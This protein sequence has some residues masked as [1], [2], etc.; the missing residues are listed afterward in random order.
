MSATVER[1]VILNNQ[2]GDPRR[3]RAV[4]ADWGLNEATIKRILSEHEAKETLDLEAP[5]TDAYT[6]RLECLTR[7]CGQS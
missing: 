4:L 5:R 1:E 2:T 6:G 7:G 3:V